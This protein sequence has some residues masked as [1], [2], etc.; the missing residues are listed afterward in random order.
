MSSPSTQISEPIIKFSNEESKAVIRS[1]ILQN[2]NNLIDLTKSTI[3]CSE[4]QDLFKTCFKTF[5]ANESLVEQSCNKFKKVEII[6]SQLNCQVDQ[7]Q[8]DCELLKE[9]CKQIDSIQKKKEHYGR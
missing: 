8:A 2:L 7:I 5:V 1:K 6:S 4:H 9:V 3:K